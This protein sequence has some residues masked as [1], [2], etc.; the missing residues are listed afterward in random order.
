VVL[1]GVS[2][3]LGG[4]R[5][6]GLALVVTG[7][8]AYAL[9]QG[10]VIGRVG[11][12]GEGFA[13]YFTDMIPKGAG[14][15]A[16]FATLA[17][18]PI[19]SAAFALSKAKLAYV[20]KMLAPLLFLPLATLRGAVLLLY[21]LGLALFA[22]RPPLYTL[23]FQYAFH[24]V[25]EAFL[26]MLVAIAKYWPDAGSRPL[27][28]S[29]RGA[30]AGV[31]F[32]SSLFSWRWGMVYPRAHFQGGFRVVRFEETDADRARY[33]AVQRLAASIPESASVTASENL[34]PHVARRGE[35]Q[36]S[37][38][39]E[40]Q[41]SLGHPDAFFIFENELPELQRKVPWIAD[42]SRYERRG[43]GG[44]AVLIV[45]RPPAPAS[46]NAP[47]ERRATTRS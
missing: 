34:V 22:S 31:A 5:R 20:V 24:V 11:G 4:A 39:V 2:L 6:R 45:R 30:L 10:L 27:G 42:A 47:Y 32:A 15:L 17:E 44:G 33:R 41:G 8:A 16:L 13:W 37:R 18:H 14:P 26:G 19:R 3:A 25:P 43:T 9:L 38:L 36:T 40:P 46:A 28:V 1:L 29:R 7:A 23:G 35:V 21:G 12:R